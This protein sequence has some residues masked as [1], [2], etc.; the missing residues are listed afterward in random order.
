M[1]APSELLSADDASELLEPSSDLPDACA[2]AT[3]MGFQDGGEPPPA[4]LSVRRRD[5]LG[6][7][8][9]GMGFQ[10]GGE[11]MCVM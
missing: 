8:A 1:R 9:T 4:L 6:A 5:A 10:D 2:L 3:G 7:R 11:L